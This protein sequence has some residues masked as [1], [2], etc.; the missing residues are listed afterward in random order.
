M[1]LELNHDVQGMILSFCNHADLKE[2]SLCSHATREITKELLWRTVCIPF[3]KFDDDN[4]HQQL[5]TIEGFKE[6]KVLKLSHTFGKYYSLLILHSL[7]IHETLK[8]CNPTTVV[9]GFLPNDAF[10]V[11]GK[12]DNLKELYLTSYN[13]TDYSLAIVYR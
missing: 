6:T 7:K 3:H 1:F 8:F 13:A 9:T 12:F 5:H 2:F 4:F 10:E 11:L